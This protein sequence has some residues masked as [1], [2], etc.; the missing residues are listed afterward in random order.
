M[1]DSKVV[2]ITGASSGIGY[3]TALAF[4]RRGYQVAGTARRADKLATLQTAV[5]TLPVGHGE[6]LPLTVDVRNAQ[7]VEAAVQAAVQHFGRL[8]ILVA[9]AGVGQRGAIV[10]AAWEDLDTLLRTNLDGL[11]HSI[12]CAVPAIRQG[13]SGGQIVLISSVVSNMTAPY[14]ATYAASKAF[15]SSLAKSLRLELEADHIG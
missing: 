12:R 9:N 6:F 1:A 10:E 4:T 11:M 5:Q 14:T 7:A 15:V 2:F 3:A 13:K 8:D